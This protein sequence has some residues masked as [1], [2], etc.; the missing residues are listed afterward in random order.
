[1][2]EL[3]TAFIHEV[4]TKEHLAVFLKGNSFSLG[5]RTENEKMCIRFR[6][7]DVSICSPDPNHTYDVLISGSKDRICS[8]LMGNEKLRN[9]MKTKT[10]FVDST[11]R[12]ILFLESLFC[13][14]KQHIS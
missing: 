8:V 9:A 14:S 3:V 7:G 6:N 4:K 12:K 11:F 1:M 5:I 2:E 10:I 13:L